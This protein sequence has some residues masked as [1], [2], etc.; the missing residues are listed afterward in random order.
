MSAGI[1]LV[2]AFLIHEARTPR[3]L[4]NLHAAFA[5]PM[6]GL[7]LLIA[8]LRLTITSTAYLIPLFLGSVRGF[9][10]L[11]VGETLLWIAAP[12]LILCP[13][14]ALMLRRSDA[15]LVASIGFIF[16][17]IACLM[18]A[19]G[20]TPIWG[21]YQ[22]LPSALLQAAGQSFALSGVVF[23]G[24]LHL[25]PQDALTFGG[26]LQT[27]RLLGGEIGTA[28]V[29]TVARVREQVASN[30]IGQHVQAGDSD[31]LNR[32]RAYGAVTTRAIDPVGAVHRGQL[33]L[34][35]AVRSAATTQSVMDAFVTVGFFTALALL[36]V[37]SRSAAPVGPAS[38]IPLFGPG[39]KQP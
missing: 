14:A 13:L 21:S 6:P 4:V 17:S 38:A 10:D 11:E 1:L 20:L 37:V 33:V 22:F 36:L 3:P 12:Q 30:L 2:A 34:A 39:S 29:T 7:L 19:Y 27:A 24:I 15:R 26:V 16:I 35:S 18:V 5:S 8:F 31:V 32:V 23:F 9:R 25:K 28:F